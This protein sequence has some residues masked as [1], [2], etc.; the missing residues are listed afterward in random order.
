MNILQELK[1]TYGIT[2]GTPEAIQ[3]SN[4]VSKALLNHQHAFTHFITLQPRRFTILDHVSTVIRD[5]F[6]GCLPGVSPRRNARF[7]ITVSIASRWFHRNL[8]EARDVYFNSKDHFMQ[9]KAWH[10]PADAYPL[11]APWH[12]HAL[13]GS[14]PEGILASSL[15]DIIAKNTSYGDVNVQMI[16]GGAALGSYITDSRRGNHLMGLQFTNDTYLYNQCQKQGVHLNW[17]PPAKNLS[18]K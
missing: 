15:T 7:F 9:S 13:V 4:I 3:H 8:T 6:A 14:L 17:C 5:E 2:V 16:Q 18:H 10:Q 12:L 11:I 1:H